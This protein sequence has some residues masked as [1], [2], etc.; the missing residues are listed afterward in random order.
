[1]EYPNVIYT[2]PGY[3]PEIDD[4]VTLHVECIQYPAAGTSKVFLIPDSF[5]CK[6]DTSND[7]HNCSKASSCPLY[8]RVE[9]AISD[10]Q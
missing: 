5:K 8:R 7:F 9:K 1:M 10:S 2:Y 6:L 4:D 3:C